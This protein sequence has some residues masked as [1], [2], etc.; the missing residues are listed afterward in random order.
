MVP[1]RS[2][3]PLTTDTGIGDRGTESARGRRIAVIPKVG[4]VAINAAHD[5]VTHGDRL[6][7]HVFDRVGVGDVAGGWPPGN[8]L[9]GMVRGQPQCAIVL[10]FIPA[11]HRDVT[12]TD[13]EGI[14]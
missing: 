12:L 4:D 1:A 11:D 13:S 2:V 9:G 14:F 8:A 5:T 7:T 3:A 10:L 6:A